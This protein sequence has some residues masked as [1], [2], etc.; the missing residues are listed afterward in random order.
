MTPDAAYVAIDTLTRLHT[1]GHHCLTPEG[2]SAW[3]NENAGARQRCPTSSLL[4][5]V[6]QEVTAL[7]QQTHAAAHDPTAVE[8]VAEGMTGLTLTEVP[9]EEAD[10][11]RA[12]ARQAIETLAAHLDG[13]PTT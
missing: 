13:I 9:A 2:T 10:G 7:H 4:D 6:R 12:L 3:F 5:G 8:T 1:G 11:L